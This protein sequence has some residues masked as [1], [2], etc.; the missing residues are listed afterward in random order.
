MSRL[1]P[2]RPQR[3]AASEETPCNVCGGVDY[4]VIARVDRERR[5]LRTVMCRS[6]GLVWTNPRPSAAAMERYYATEYRADYAGAPTPALR[7][8]LRGLA[9]ARERHA[10]LSRLLSTYAARGGATVRALDVG[11]GAGELVFLL[12]HAGLDA[13]GLEPGHDFADFARRVLRIPVITAT[14]DAAVIAPD[15][16]DVVTM[17]HALEHVS[18]PRGVLALV[19]GWTKRGGLVVV[20]VPN[21]EST[22][23]APA[24]RFH[25]AHL[26]SF[27]GATLGAVGEAA[28]LRVVTS[29]FSGDGG[30]VTCVFRRDTDEPR[31]PEGLARQASRTRSILAAHTPLRHYLSTKPYGRALS[32]LR[33]RWQED[34]VLR[35]HRTME[36]LLRWG[37]GTD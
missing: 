2:A 15:S 8:V 35:R 11:C 22:V 37:T 36:D 4:D 30:N 24:H 28:G 19:R 1:A 14:V 13:E 23:Q 33:R 6:C 20:E 10:L 3:P 9:G 34:R 12:R 31:L 26:Y 25:Y 32:R 29:V 17:F 5:P 21:V 27:S 16:F 7:K 18:D